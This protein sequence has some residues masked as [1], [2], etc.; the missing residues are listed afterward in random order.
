[1]QPKACVSYGESDSSERLNGE[2]EE[3]RRRPRG[4]NTAGVIVRTKWQYARLIES[5]LGELN[6][7]DARERAR[8]EHQS[9]TPE[10]KHNKEVTEDEENSTE[11]KKERNNPALLRNSG[12][13]ATGRSTRWTLEMWGTVKSVS[14][15]KVRVKKPKLGQQE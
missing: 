12:K 4:Q 14:E 13:P 7:R 9:T 6:R 10:R 15:R 11:E 1:M 3:Q 8:P 5:T 2:A